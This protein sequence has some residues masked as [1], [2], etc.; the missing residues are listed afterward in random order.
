MTG[1][2]SIATQRQ[3]GLRSDSVLFKYLVFSRFIDAQLGN[4]KLD[5][6]CGHLVMG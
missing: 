4:P 5:K 1:K 2:N 3:A 6:A